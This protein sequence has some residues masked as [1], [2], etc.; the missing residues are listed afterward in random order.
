MYILY[1]DFSIKNIHS[2]VYEQ[3]VSKYCTVQELLYLYGNLQLD[4]ILQWSSA[5]VAPDPK[6]WQKVRPQTA[7]IYKHHQLRHAREGSQIDDS[8][9]NWRHSSSSG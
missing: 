8:S 3:L 9:H 7:Y 2:L 6:S 5:R 1:W 4:Y